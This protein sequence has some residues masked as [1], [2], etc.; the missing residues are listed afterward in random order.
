MAVKQTGIVLCMCE[1][2]QKSLITITATLSNK[3]SACE[4][5]LTKSLG[6]APFG[7]L[8]AG[9]TGIVQA[10]LLG[11]IKRISELSVFCQL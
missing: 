5:R 1:R 2:S 4:A 6:R 10:I 7:I 9:H 11:M 8:D 3:D